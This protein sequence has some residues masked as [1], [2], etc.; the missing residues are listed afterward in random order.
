[1]LTGSEITALLD[2]AVHTGLFVLI[3]TFDEADIELA[4]QLVQ[5]ADRRAHLLVGVNCRDLT[6]LQVVPGRLEALAAQL[7]RAVP[8]V[9]ESG[10]Q[11]CEDAARL[12]RAGYDVALV[13]SAL[14]RS[15]QPLQLARSMLAAGRAA[16]A[17]AAAPA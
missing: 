6:S 16:A 9:A 8:R 1:M 11:N 15:P 10:V 2:S 5:R 14:M 12:V 4:T 17:T 7:P 13:G 3:E